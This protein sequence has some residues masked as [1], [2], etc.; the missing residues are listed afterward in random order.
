[1]NDNLMH[2]VASVIREHYYDELANKFLALYTEFENNKVI[3]FPRQS[4]KQIIAAIEV[5]NKFWYERLILKP[6][7]IEIRSWL[8]KHD[9][10]ETYITDFKNDW[11]ELAIEAGA[12]NE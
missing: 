7:T 4:G 1:M 12:L 9:C 10:F 2:R 3:V 11:M 5:M 6:N 8:G